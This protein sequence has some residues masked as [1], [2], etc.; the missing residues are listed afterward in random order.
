MNKSIRNKILMSLVLLFTIA[1]A[2]VGVLSFN[3]TPVADASFAGS[4]T[5]LRAG[6]PEDGDKKGIRFVS[7]ISNS[8]IEG[9]KKDGY[10]LTY[11]TFIMPD[12]YA[13]PSSQKFH[14]ELT[15][16]NLF[17][18][19][20]KYVWGNAQGDSEKYWVIHAPAD[21]TE[22]QSTSLIKASVNMINKDNWNIKY[23]AKA[24][25][26]AVKGED[27]Q[28]LLATSLEAQ[29]LLD[30]VVTKMDEPDV[31]EDP[32]MPAILEGFIT[33]YENAGGDVIVDYEIVQS[34]GGKEV[35]VTDNATA[36]IGEVI[37]VSAYK[38]SLHDYASQL[39]KDSRYYYYDDTQDLGS[40]RVKADGS[41]KIV[42][43]ITAKQTYNNKANP[44]T[45]EL[46][47]LNGAGGYENFAES[48]DFELSGDKTFTLTYDE[49]KGLDKAYTH[50]V[51]NFDHPTEV[52]EIYVRPI[53]AVL[54]TK[55]EI[56][57][58]HLYGPYDGYTFAKGLCFD[59]DQDIDMTGY[60]NGWTSSTGLAGDGSYTSHGFRGKLYGNGHVLY[61][62][63][64]RLFDIIGYTGE[65]RD[66]TVIGNAPNNGAKNSM[67][68][69]SRANYGYIMD[70]RFE[71]SVLET[72]TISANYA[73]TGVVFEHMYSYN[74]DG[75]AGAVVPS[76]ENT[77]VRV[78]GTNNIGSTVFGRCDTGMFDNVHVFTDNPNVFA[79]GKAPAEENMP[80]I[81]GLNDSF[82]GNEN[83]SSNKWSF[84]TDI[85]TLYNKVIKTG[86]GSFAAYT[87]NDGNTD[88]VANA[89][90]VVVNIDDT[91]FTVTNSALMTQP[92]GKFAQVVKVGD[93]DGDV[94]A[95]ITID[96]VTAY[97]SSQDDV[98][99]I[100]LLAGYNNP[101][102]VTVDSAS[103]DKIG[104][105]EKFVLTKNI[106]MSGV[107]P[108]LESSVVAQGG[109]WGAIGFHGT[110]EGNGFAITNLNA[111]L[112]NVIGNNGKINNLAF[113]AD[114]VIS[115]NF[116][117]YHYGIVDNCYFDYTSSGDTQNVLVSYA[118]GGTFKN[119]VFKVNSINTRA[120]RYHTF[121]TAYL[122][123]NVQR[124]FMNNSIVIT[125][126]P[127][128]Y[129]TVGNEGLG[130]APTVLGLNDLTSAHVDT[131][132]ANG[133]ND[134]VW[135]DNLTFKNIAINEDKDDNNMWAKWEYAEGVYNARVANEDKFEKGN[136]VSVDSATLTAV[137]DG[138]FYSA[139]KADENS[140][141]RTYIRVI[142]GFLNNASEVA[143]FRNLCGGDGSRARYFGYL[144]ITSD[145]EMTSSFALGNN[146]SSGSYF[147]DSAFG[148]VIDG[149]DHS[150]SNPKSMMFNSL[151]TEYG[152]IIKNLKFLNSPYSFAGGL[153]I[154]TFEDCEFDFRILTNSKQNAVSMYG[155]LAD[156]IGASRTVVVKDTDIKVQNVTGEM[157]YVVETIGSNGS[158][159]YDNVN[160]YA[161]EKW[162]GLSVTAN[163]SAPTRFAHTLNYYDEGRT[164]Y[165]GRFI[166]KA[167][168]TG[169]EANTVSDFSVN[170]GENGVGGEV[171]TVPR[172]TFNLTNASAL[173]VPYG[174]GVLKN[175]NNILVKGSLGN[176]YRI[177]IEGVYYAINN[178]DDYINMYKVIAQRTRSNIQWIG[179]N[180]DLDLEGVTQIASD[181]KDSS[182]SWDWGWA[183]MFLGNNK[184]VKNLGT[185]FMHYVGASADYKGGIKDLTFKDMKETGTLFNKTSGGLIE[186]V[187]FEFDAT[188]MSRV[189]L[190]S[191]V[192]NNRGSASD[193]EG[194]A[195][196]MRNCTA[197]VTG[198]SSSFQLCAHRGPNTTYTPGIVIV[199]NMDVTM[200]AGSFSVG[201]LDVPA[202]WKDS[203]LTSGEA[204]NKIVSGQLNADGTFTNNTTEA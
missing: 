114:N 70:C 9:L 119:S 195:M 185:S 140:Y 67:G 93:V 33:E 120:N 31:A 158:L 14:A 58:I 202:T 123:S 88:R 66:L 47:K 106:D 1:V 153:G 5:K 104:A 187:K 80:T 181:D 143:N 74:V 8:V 86:S 99:Y 44:K 184:T 134:N 135:T 121:R 65:I 152:A 51:Q 107:A 90:N 200:N 39:G 146:P 132:K 160:L 62:L 26:K 94:F 71:I 155:V 166:R 151:G 43:D 85:P 115:N 87:L 163:A 57:D 37:D 72:A 177:T 21:L 98:K 13:D 4:T 194:T 126:S 199:E 180:V 27:T 162:V 191:S 164:F 108:V 204:T 91:E 129:S 41:T 10:A 30:V 92:T 60:N 84:E 102:K 12:Y 38:A 23:V 148:G 201:R 113:I 169:S 34:Y 116:V 49:V 55:D 167:D 19:N 127:S 144:V 77:V 178:V 63:N 186:N 159:T 203:T 56:E 193:L 18:A 118:Y 7:E 141:S 172:S 122:S 24:Y 59:I 154:V 2:L 40:L 16:E 125:N 52:Y 97:I 182:Q 46:V 136:T 3:S 109:K 79:E 196:V 183:S 101:T 20:P 192:N 138:G 175:A 128:W 42:I 174:G 6:Q 83:F 197:V 189:V 73:W 15:V 78:K 35:A 50:L 81:Y 112:F 69:I 17:G 82:A 165:Y 117:N 170:L 22:G 64:S 28:Y 95:S 54:S 131:F 11:G 48:Y 133:G 147:D 168:N 124:W 176:Y 53:T 156:N 130:A 157:I 75:V 171:L 142:T 149:K 29:S 110:I 36:K 137:M 145:V 190:I 139:S 150:I 96:K 68:L 25:V 100:S 76:V 179:L 103:Y 105:G 111:P 188:G 198:A 161:Q 61:N 32:D 89:E 45:I 173:D